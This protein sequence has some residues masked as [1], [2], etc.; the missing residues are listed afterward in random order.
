M[1]CNKEEAVRAKQLSEKKMEIRDF[2]GALKIA[3]KA[4]QLYPELE[5]ISQLI[6]VCEVHCS[7][8]KKSYGTDK[9]WYGILKIEPSADDIAIKKQYRKLALLLHPDKN[10]FPG[11]TDAFK[12]IGEAQRVLLDREKRLIHDSKRRAFGNIS[13]PSRTSNVQPHQHPWNQ[14]HPGNFTRG[15]SGNFQFTQ[16]R[17]PTG[18]SG[19][20]STFWTACPFCSVRY[21]F[22]RNT[23]NTVILCQNCKK[24]FSAYEYNMHH[25]PVAP[26]T[27]NTHAQKHQNRA[28]PK[29]AEGVKRT[30]TTTPV[31]EKKE[32]FKTHGN[33]NRKRKKRVEESSESSDNSNSVPENLD[34]NQDNPNFQYFGEPRRR[35]SRSKRNVSYKENINE[36]DIDNV[37]DHDAIPSNPAENGA[38]KHAFSK[39][40]VEQVAE[41]GKTEF[42]DKKSENHKAGGSANDS[43][44]EEE[45]EP[46]VFE[47]PDPE[48]ND[49]EK[50]RKEESFSAGQIWACY[51][52]EDAMPRFYALI[53]KISPGFKLQIQWL[54]PDPVTTDE[55]NWVGMDLPVSCGRYKRE[56]HDKSQDILSFSHSILWEAS[57]KDKTLIIVPR[58]GQ[59]WALFKNWSMNWHSC[60]LNQE[61]R[62]YEYEFVEILSDFDEKLGVRVAYMEKVKGFV[63]LFRRKEG[64]E[65][66]IADSEKY[67]FAHMVP[68]CRMSG[69]ERDG[70]PK[71][72]Y[73]LDPAALPAST[74][75]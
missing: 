63:C 67:R 61:E 74:F 10:N 52:T 42:E 45:I 66:V 58:K 3:V 62:K 54:K 4:Q 36:V 21:E 18:V 23:L 38:K 24:S 43:D 50:Y 56:K 1:D 69:E 59:T 25:A 51:D 5:N 57:Q 32:P 6:I 35:S 29:P 64:G 9:D 7:A 2:S 60:N 34:D 16:Q 53:K 48:F 13:A 49:F 14:G 20:P 65:T 73:E 44:T 30:F 33:V 46:E 12:L 22:Y 47:C 26:A 37:E 40:T 39:K 11:S 68:S 27:N 31:F 55:K 15:Y 75:E 19:H 8:E 70:V 72:S 17:A 41:N 71:G 28:S